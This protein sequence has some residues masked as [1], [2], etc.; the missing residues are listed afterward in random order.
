MT[1]F[2]FT[3]D[4]LDIF[5]IAAGLTDRG[6]LVSRDTWPVPAIRFMQS[7]G[8]APLV[9]RYLEDLAEVVDLVRRGEITAAEGRADYT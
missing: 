7:L 9:D 6:W 2:A 4:S 3:S 8:H 5:A 1:I